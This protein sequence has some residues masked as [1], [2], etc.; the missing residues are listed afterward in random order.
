[1]IKKTFVAAGL[2]VLTLSLPAMAQGYG[3]SNEPFNQTFYDANGNPTDAVIGRHGLI[4]QNQRHSDDWYIGIH[5]GVAIAADSTLSGG[6][7]DGGSA[8][9]GLGPQFNLALGRHLGD[10]RVEGEVGYQTNDLDSIDYP[11]GSINNIDGHFDALSIMFNGYYDIQLW[12]GIDL[13]IGGG[14][15][16]A[17]DHLSTSGPY[18]NLPGGTDW[19]LAYQAMAGVAFQIADGVDLDLGYRFWNS[20]N[21]EFD[22][23]TVDSPIR[24][25]LEIGIRFDL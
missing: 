15:G 23:V 7:L 19:V 13:Y 5:G 10:F 24:H 11:G 18:A 21:P 8:N 14:V 16:A 9:F 25:S 20:L 6:I 1:M 2:L 4:S 12:K 22:G 17:G 3:Y